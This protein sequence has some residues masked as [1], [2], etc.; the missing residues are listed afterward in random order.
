MNDT[1]EGGMG[2]FAKGCLSLL[3]V[4]ALLIVGIGAAGWYVY[5][6][7][8]GNFTAA[9]PVDL[10]IPAPSDAQFAA[11]DATLNRLRDAIANGREAT[12]EFT[13]TDL[14][15][16]VARHPDFTDL[17]GKCR[18]GIEDSVMTVEVSAPLDSSGLPQ[19]R[20]RWF[21]GILRFSFVFEQ[22]QFSFEPK[23]AEAAGHAVPRAFLSPSFTSS[24]NQN[25]SRSFR[26]AVEKKKG[27]E[28]AFWKHIKS[29]MVQGDKLLVTTDASSPVA[30][31]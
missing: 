19:T 3:V 6:R 29:M 10:H 18:F 22:G 11:A 21:N 27:R 17:R 15:A 8:I 2:C 24:F 31:R 12:V 20:G 16:L 13:A 5:K 23:S 30:Q 14:N 28:A 1:R 26:E 4:G 7:A 9:G 25:F